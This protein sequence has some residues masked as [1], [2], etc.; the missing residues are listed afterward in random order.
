LT[1]FTNL[2]TLSLGIVSGIGCN[3]EELGDVFIDVSNT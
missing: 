3:V 2:K 1:E